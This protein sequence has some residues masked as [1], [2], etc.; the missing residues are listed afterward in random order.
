MQSTHKDSIPIT[1]ISGFL[2]AGKT[3]F[4]NQLIARGELEENSLILVN[5]FGSINVDSQLIEYQNDRIIKLS[6]GCICC[7]LGGTLAEQLAEVVRLPLPVAA[8][9]IEASGVSDPKK[10]A[11]ITRVSRRFSLSDIVCLVDGSRLSVNSANSRVSDIWYAQISSATKILLN[12]ADK[13]LNRLREQL[14]LINPTADITVAEGCVE[15]ASTQTL[16]IEAALSNNPPPGKGGG[17]SSFSQT[18]DIP[19]DQSW[20]EE[21]FNRF[22]AVLVRAK[23][24]IYLRGHRDAQVLQFSGNTLSLVPTL[25]KP[26]KGELVCIGVKSPAFDELIQRLE[27]VSITQKKSVT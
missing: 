1:V 4:L 21:L 18:F 10:I 2:G 24:I 22:G 11:D 17:F 3:T 5:D 26:A 16:T 15:G 6:N 14:M 13:D 9:Y 25:R 20:L 8:I 19:V 27:L 12:R 23:G 7:T